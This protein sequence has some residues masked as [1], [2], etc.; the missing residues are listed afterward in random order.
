MKKTILIA[1]ITLSA[2]TAFGQAKRDTSKHLSFSTPEI[3]Q[4]TSALYKAIQVIH[5]VDMSSKKRDSIDSIVG[6]V[7]NFILQR[8]TETYHPAKDKKGAGK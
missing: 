3:D 4:I 2:A 1:A 7:Y 6:S 5:T 8:E